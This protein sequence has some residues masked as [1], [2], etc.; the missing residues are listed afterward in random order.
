MRSIEAGF[1]LEAGRVSSQATKDDCRLGSGY[2]RSNPLEAFTLVEL[3]VV[4]AVI[5]LL[6]ALLLPALERARESA[7]NIKCKNNFRQ[8]GIALS[9][10]LN[11]YH[12]YIHTSVTDEQTGA[13]SLP[14]SLLEP[15]LGSTRPTLG[16]IP[17]PEIWQCPQRRTFYYGYNESGI[18]PFWRV[19]TLGLDGFPHNPPVAEHA[20]ESPSDMIAFY[21]CVSFDR[22]PFINGTRLHDFRPP[23]TGD[24]RE[25]YAHRQS[26]NS[27]FCDAHVESLHRYDFA[28]KSEQARRRWNSDNESHDEDWPEAVLP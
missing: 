22:G 3:L 20:V 14:P 4:S 23:R 12:Y 26:V 28:A 5:A 8:A 27:A 1:L 11:D 10:Y 2:I 15:Y 9:M 16:N 13:I 7:I 6:A 24:Q 18:G 25:S 19:P 17:F 21:E